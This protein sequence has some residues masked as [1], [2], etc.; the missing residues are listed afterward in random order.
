MATVHIDSGLHAF[1]PTLTDIPEMCLLGA[2]KSQ[3]G[4]EDEPLPPWQ[5][6][7]CELIQKMNRLVQK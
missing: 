5:K 7:P 2:S 3:Y 4:N 6:S 1:P